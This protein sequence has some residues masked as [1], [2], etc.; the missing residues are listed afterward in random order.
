MTM[1][2][3]I[4]SAF[5]WFNPGAWWV[6]AQARLSR[7]QLVDSEVVRL[8]AREPYVK[9]LLSMAV[10]SRRGWDSSCRIVLN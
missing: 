6:L 10:V 9:A 1:V 2:E 5:L 4:F 3:E 7:E 8:T